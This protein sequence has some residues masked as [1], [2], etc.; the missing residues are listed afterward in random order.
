MKTLINI[1]A[2]LLL[3]AL[4]YQEVGATHNRAGEITYVHA[5]LD[6]KPYRYEFTVVTYT[7]TGGISDSADRDSLRV[8]WGDGTSSML[9]R[10]N[11]AISQGQ[12]QGEFLENDIKKNEYKGT[13]TYSNFFFF[14]VVS[15][16][17][18]NRIDEVVN[19]NF[20]ESVDIPFFIQDTLFLLD[21][22]FFGYNNSPVLYQPPID[23][24]NVGYPFVHNP[25]AFDVDG[26]SL[27]FELIPPLEG[28][29]VPVP[30]YQYPDEIVNTAANNMT[31]NSSTG[32]FIWDAPQ[33]EGIYNIAFLIREF[34][35]GVQIGNIIRDMQ[36]IVEDLN[37]EPPEI[38][39][40]NDTCV[41]IGESLEI[42]VTAT[43]PNED[44][45]V[46]LSAFGGPFEIVDPATFTPLV[47]NGNFAEWLF[48][49][50][51]NCNHIFSDE[52]TIVFKA[53]DDFVHNGEPTP[54]VDLETW[55]VSVVPPPPADLLAQIIP[56]GVQIDWA[57]PYICEDTDKFLGFSIWRAV[58]C[59]EEVFDNC[60][61][62]L[63]GTNYVKLAQGVKEYTFL[64]ETAVRGLTYSYR[65]VA[66]FSDVLTENAF[67]INLVASQPSEN[68]C[69]ELPR[70]APIITNVSIE[71]TDMNGQV[72]I[73]WV[74]PDAEALDT[75]ANPGPYKYELKRE[76]A[77]GF[78]TIQTFNYNSFGETH[79][80]EW[81]DTNINTVDQPWNYKLSFYSQNDIRID[82]TEEASSPFLSIT[83]TD[84][85]LN[86][87][88]EAIVPWLNYEYKFYRYN[89]ATASYEFLTNTAEPYYE[90]VD[91][92]NGKSYCYYVECIGTY[93]SD[94]EEIPDP[95][96]NLSQ[97][98]CDEPIDTE[99]PCPPTLVVGNDCDIEGEEW[100]EEEY[101]NDLSWN[102]P[103]DD[104]ADDVIG[105]YIYYG[106]S[107]AEN[108]SL[109]DSTFDATNTSYEHLLEGTLSGCYAVTAIDSFYN[110]SVYSNIVCKENCPKFEL[111]NVFT[112]NADNQNDL[113]V[114]LRGNRFVSTIKMEIFSRWGELV[115]ETNDPYINWD[116]RHMNGNEVAEGVYYYTCDV[117]ERNSAGQEIR[118]DRL[119]GYIQLMR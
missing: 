44:Q 103:N 93:G 3:F 64:D 36:V 91:L 99:A 104:C 90:D 4:F 41:Y 107:D 33:Q 1:I 5:P 18:P 42:V 79:E 20:S 30:N 106:F 83:P 92:I 34:R 97:E 54:L 115:Y 76:D 62:G 7:K 45:T 101:T 57:S 70:D 28:I 108:Y 89:N 88:V 66:E 59:D 32:E 40:L 110:E 94:E 22:Q 72:F 61:R 10:T 68:I 87:S 17:D 25:N 105:Y 27:Y 58:G 81:Q 6:G 60:E 69:V 50:D 19:I 63:N 74:K 82:D 37:N 96:I 111:P 118:F 116:G 21:P 100:E 117:F 109:I 95:L 77:N 15:M 47:E 38:M 55:Q 31:L 43:D 13:H 56:E 114:P 24:A 23:Y 52:Y 75:I 11:G 53:S 51:T 35:N 39:A 26:D 46:T 73:A 98:L 12:Y 78:N 29:G 84:N 48:N 86:L 102:N 9:P 8:E 85:Q 16:E 67:P 49:W 2:L 80:T 65:V 119:S 113:F 112:P 14:Y 71:E